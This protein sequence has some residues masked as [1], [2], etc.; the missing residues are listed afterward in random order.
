M[1]LCTDIWC[2][3]SYFRENNVVFELFYVLLWENDYIFARD[4]DVSMK[5]R[6]VLSECQNDDKSRHDMAYCPVCGQKLAQIRS[7][8]HRSVTRHKCRRCKKFIDVIAEE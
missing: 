6:T 5:I 4:N 2:K 8:F 1:K 7:V 3:Y